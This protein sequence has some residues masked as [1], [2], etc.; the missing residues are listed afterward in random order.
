MRILSRLLACLAAA[1]LL[2]AQP[3][4]AQSILRDSET[5]ALLQDMVDPLVVAAGMPRGSVDVVLINDP[6]MNAFVQQ[7]QT[8]YIHSGLINA[9]DNANQV[10]GVL[11]HE[12]GHIIGGHALRFYEGY[13][14][15]MKINVLSILAGIAAMASLPENS[16][17]WIRAQDVAMQARAQLER[18][19]D[20]K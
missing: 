2:G 14:N 8:I 5:E 10:Q 7:G 18:Q 11:A 20:R 12:L 19:K 13:G 3:A 6:T 16:P 15:A 4:A 17:D 9:A 1:C